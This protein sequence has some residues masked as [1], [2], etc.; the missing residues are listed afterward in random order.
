MAATSPSEPQRWPCG[1]VQPLLGRPAHLFWPRIAAPLSSQGTSPVARTAGIRHRHAFRHRAGPLRRDRC[2]A[3]HVSPID[4]RNVGRGIT[5]MTQ[6]TNTKIPPGEVQLCTKCR[7]PMSV[8]DVFPTMPTTGLDEDELVY[9][10]HRIIF[11]ACSR[12]PRITRDRTGR[13]ICSTLVSVRGPKPS[14]S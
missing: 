8:S 14:A 3:P 9:R 6:E 10:C 12:I 11:T 7:I 2:F 5:I 1:K 4:R 13:T